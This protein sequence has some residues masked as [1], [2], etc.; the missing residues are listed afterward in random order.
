MA[1]QALWVVVLA[2]VDVATSTQSPAAVSLPGTVVPP[3]SG[4][5][6]APS[7]DPSL[8]PEQAEHAKMSEK[9]AVVRTVQ[10]GTGCHMRL[11]TANVVPALEQLASQL[12]E[13][14]R[15]ALFSAAFQRSLEAMACSRCFATMPDSL[16]PKIRCR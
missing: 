5:A 11:G 14:E 8:R 3:G 9:T 1:V 16:G 13:G 2:S 6:V 15:H 7:G 10:A 12:V 4:V